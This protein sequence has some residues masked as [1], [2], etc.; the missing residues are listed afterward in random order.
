MEK[1]NLNKYGELI[2]NAI[3]LAF[4][5]EQDCNEEF[6]KKDP[7]GVGYYESDLSSINID[8]LTPSGKE[9]ELMDFLEE[10]DY[11]LTKILCIMMW[12]GRDSS[13][14]ESDGTYNYSKIRESFDKG[15][16]NTD[17][18]AQIN[19]LVEKFHLYT[20]LRKGIEKL[21]IRL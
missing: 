16:W 5:Y 19:Y 2:K 7:D 6:R 9:K 18:S 4:E 3:D 20:Y 13:L 17:K 12:V 8:E 1:I 15:G 10:N 11:E 21:N 14:Q